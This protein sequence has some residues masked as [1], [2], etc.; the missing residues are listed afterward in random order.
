MTV[1]ELIEKLKQF[2]ANTPV[3][4]A[5][6]PEGNG[7]D[8]LYEVVDFEVYETEEVEPGEFE[9]YLKYDEMEEVSKKHNKIVMLWP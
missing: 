7:F 2:D 4:V 9:T 3:W 5:K 6:D 8:S 1:A